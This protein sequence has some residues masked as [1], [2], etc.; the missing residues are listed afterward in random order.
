MWI[1]WFTVLVSHS[2]RCLDNADHLSYRFL[3]VKLCISDLCG[4]NCDE[5]ILD[6]LEHLPRG[7]SELLD[8]K[9][10]RVEKGNDGMQATKLL[11]FCGVLKRPLTAEEYE[12]LLAISID[13]KLLDT[14][15]IPNSMN[16]II[17]GCYGLTF[18]DDEER[19]VHFVHQSVKMHLFDV[20]NKRV[21]K[22]DRRDVDKHMGLLCMTYL[23][24]SNF[25]KQVTKT[26]K[27][28]KSVL[29]P[30][31]MGT[32]SV[33]SHDLRATGLVHKLY[34][35][36]ERLLGMKFREF[37][38]NA[39]ESRDFQARFARPES[40]SHS[41]PFL[42]YAKTHWCLHLKELEAESGSK[43]WLLFCKCIEDKTLPLDRPWESYVWHSSAGLPFKSA[44]AFQL[45]MAQHFVLVTCDPVSFIQAL[46]SSL[47]RDFHEV[48][49]TFHQ[50]HFALF[51]YFLRQIQSSSS[52]TSTTLTRTLRYNWIC[53]PTFTDGSTHRW[54]DML[55][56]VPGLTNFWSQSLY[57]VAEDSRIPGEKRFN[58]FLDILRKMKYFD[59]K[60]ASLALGGALWRAVFVNN[61][62]DFMLAA[63]KAFYPKN[64]TINQK[65][66]TD[67]TNSFVGNVE[68][69]TTPV[70][71]LAVE[72]GNH[73][74]LQEL[75]DAG[76]NVNVRDNYGE[77][78]LVK[79]IKIGQ[80]EK[81]KALVAAGAI[82]YQHDLN[83]GILVHAAFLILAETPEIGEVPLS[84]GVDFDKITDRGITALQMAVMNQGIP[85][86]QDQTSVIK[87]F[88]DVGADVDARNTSN[89]TALH[90]AIVHKQTE[91]AKTLV[92]ANADVNL[93]G[94][95]NRTALHIAV[96]QREK[97]LVELL[98]AAGA[99]VN[100]RDESNCTA[101]HMAA[102]Q[103]EGEVL[104]L[105]VAAHADV[106]SRDQRSQTALHMAV[107]QCEDQELRPFCSS[108][109]LFSTN[110]SSHRIDIDESCRGKRVE[111]VR[112]L[113]DAGAEVDLK[114]DDG[115]TA[116]NLASK[117]GRDELMRILRPSAEKTT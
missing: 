41:F 24:F 66:E 116:Y 68:I 83:S 107:I 21:P 109:V 34:P 98:V 25:S 99:D 27:S 92:A 113:L 117:L 85:A 33:S 69:L 36:T 51:Q 91:V 70:L 79:A 60:G 82:F 11:Q 58:I 108:D 88:L 80:T 112:V 81:M 45:Y 42:S 57:S 67:Q 16:R 17:R 64:S 44:D 75:L 101:L 23:N 73:R 110:V 29:E 20:E 95:F 9:L 103:G 8:S 32:S 115:L 28:G 93:R 53:F 78:A 90:M 111:M 55:V 4:Q 48:V 62:V 106:N 14:R 74:T 22:F 65:A 38:K 26:D 52:S 96:I 43:F 31:Q 39:L 49:W 87:A 40:Q 76:A 1:I 35:K 47:A 54:V 2:I 10:R 13:D 77:T 86:S 6:T 46:S 89:D 94:R 100:A 7:L 56:G 37:E 105:L 59:A 18:I 63:D 30:L 15:K 61:L 84:A 71:H 102:T 114:T 3:W 72:R 5:D 97:A 12:E 50:R 104:K 19:T